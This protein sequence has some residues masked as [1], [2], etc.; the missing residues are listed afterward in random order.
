LGE[1]FDGDPTA[2][3]FR[4]RRLDTFARWI[5]GAGGA[6]LPLAPPELVT[7]FRSQ[8]E[9]TRRLYGEAAG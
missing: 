5:L 4:V 8:V 9:A 7:E 1:P 6:V 2:R 3:R